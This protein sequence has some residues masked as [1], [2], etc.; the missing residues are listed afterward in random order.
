MEAL[1][2][3]AEPEVVLRRLRQH[4]RELQRYGVRSLSLFGSVARGEAESGS[5]VDLLVEFAVP[6]GLFT[7]VRLQHYLEG[8][9]GRRVDLVTPEAIRPQMRAR[10]EAEAILA[11]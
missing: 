8:L 9:L 11:A 4:T 1:V 7:Y 3:P 10:I 6:V 5:D 2:T